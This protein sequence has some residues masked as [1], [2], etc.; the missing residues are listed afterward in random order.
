MFIGH[1]P[2]G[3]VCS[4]YIHKWTG[5]GFDCPKPWMAT[6]LLGAIAPD[7][8]LIYFYLF[9]DRQHHHHSYW[10]HFPIVWFLILLLGTFLLN[11]RYR[12]LAWLTVIFSIN[13]II[14]LILDSIAG[15]VRWLAPF[16]DRTFALIEVKAL[17]KPWWMNF[18][19]HWTFGLELTLLGWAIYLAARKPARTISVE[20]KNSPPAEDRIQEHDT[21]RLS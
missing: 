3:Y 5:K 12:S 14:H 2:A 13:G 21:N 17:Y 15:D 1:L 20:P 9:D 18:F 4:R 10:P 6:C 19:F 7:L 16:S 11:T 8:D